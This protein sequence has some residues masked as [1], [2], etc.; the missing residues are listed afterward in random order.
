MHSAC[1]QFIHEFLDL[2]QGSM[3]VV[4]GG[5]LEARRATSIQVRTK[6]NKLAQRCKNSENY[7]TKPV[8]RIP[9][10]QVMARATF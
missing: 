9:C 8:P 10:L 3:L 6:L 7:C 4:E 5:E 1:T 2:I